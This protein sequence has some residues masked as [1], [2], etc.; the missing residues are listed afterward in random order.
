MGTTDRTRRLALLCLLALGIVGFMLTVTAPS[1]GPPLDSVVTSEGLV[2]EIPQGWEQSEQFGFQFHPP[3]GLAE[4]F[5]RWTVARAC[6]PDGCEPRSL[7][8]WLDEAVSLPTFVQARAPESELEVVED[9]FGDDYR[10]MLTRTTAGT[11]IVFAAAFDDG[12][13][14][15]VECGLSLSIGGDSRLIDEILDVCRATVPATG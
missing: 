11:A 13:D 12:A 3:T 4:V 14:F 10:F 7:D 5:D 9:R 2:T 6:G 8:A 15:Y 1:D